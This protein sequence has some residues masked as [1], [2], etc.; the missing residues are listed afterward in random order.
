[1]K[2]FLL[3]SACV[4]AVT[5][6]FGSEVSFGDNEGSVRRTFV[7]ARAAQREVLQRSSSEAANQISINIAQGN[8]TFSLRKV[9]GAISTD[10]SFLLPTTLN[11]VVKQNSEGYELQLEKIESG[12]FIF[13][14][15]KENTSERIMKGTFSINQD[16]ANTKTITIHSLETIEDIALNH[17]G[18]IEIQS[19]SSVLENSPINIYIQSTAIN[20]IISIARRHQRSTIT[21]KTLM[22]CTQGKVLQEGLCRAK[23]LQVSCSEFENSGAMVIDSI[24]EFATSSFKNRGNI[25]VLEG[26]HTIINAETFINYG[27]ISTKKHLKLCGESGINQAQRDGGSNDAEKRALIYAGRCVTLEFNSFKNSGGDDTRLSALDLKTSTESGGI[28]AG[29]I[30]LQVECMSNYGNICSLG[31][32][33]GNISSFINQGD[34]YSD[35]NIDLKL[36]TYDDK[37][38]LN[39]EFGAVLRAK[40]RVMLVLSKQLVLYG[41]I[42]AKELVFAGGRAIIFGV[43]KARSIIFDTT[44]SVAVCGE[45]DGSPAQIYAE[46]EIAWINVKSVNLSK[47][48]LYA[49][50]I[51]FG[52][53]H[54]N[55]KIHSLSIGEDTLIHAEYLYFNLLDLIVSGRDIYVVGSRYI[56]LICERG[57]LY[58]KLLRMNLQTHNDGTLCIQ[59]KES[60]KIPS[61]KDN[62]FFFYH[63]DFTAKEVEIEGEVIPGN[64]TIALTK[65]SRELSLQNTYDRGMQM[66]KI[67]TGKRL[68]VVGRFELRDGLSVLEIE[69]DAYLEILG[70]MNV[71]RIRNWGTLKATG[72]INYVNG[73]INNHGFATFNNLYLWHFSSTYLGRLRPSF[74]IKGN[75]IFCSE[76]T[77]HE[78]FKATYGNN[79]SLITSSISSPHIF[80]MI[81]SDGI[82]EGNF[83]FHGNIPLLSKG[84][85]GHFK[86][87]PADPSIVESPHDQNGSRLSVYKGISSTINHRFSLFSM[88]A[89]QLTIGH[90]ESDHTEVRLS[91]DSSIIRDNSRITPGK[92]CITAKKRDETLMDPTVLPEVPSSEVVVRLKPPFLGSQKV[93]RL[94]P[95]VV[96]FDWKSECGLGLKIQSVI[97]ILEGM[98]PSFHASE[99]SQYIRELIE[100]VSHS[101]PAHVK[102][103]LEG[104]IQNKLLTSRGVPRVLEKAVPAGTKKVCKGH[105]GNDKCTLLT[106]ARDKEQEWRGT[107]ANDP[108]IAKGTLEIS[109]VPE[110]K[111]VDVIDGTFEKAGP[112]GLLAILLAPILA[113]A[114]NLAHSYRPYYYYSHN[115]NESTCN[116]SKIIETS[117]AYTARFDLSSVVTPLR[118]LHQDILLA[119]EKKRL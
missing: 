27:K 38:T 95:K 110:F 4:S 59:T 28:Q 39:L 42:E 3:L 84:S 44:E 107:F 103:R 70:G 97:N 32:I 41:L 24:G 79:S 7:E 15:L 9:N 90:Q 60:L 11:S 64:L 115:D 10:L 40:S 17:D 46:V 19:I 48:R 81:G 65:E 75:L 61:V 12:S 33:I 67:K 106:T 86:M 102:L 45:S 43:A 74:T 13:V 18:N 109:N 117:A 37:Q 68:W 114:T 5:V 21:A 104:F 49:K 62:G 34:V 108:T 93:K 105:Q 92:I 25:S 36:E 53:M 77:M 2:K 99:T 6:N 57:A 30:I 56:G 87:E 47:A 116:H 54:V 26:E 119:I 72:E 52:K 101:D 71:D 73:V 88:R 63:G 91:A 82:V 66:F 16:V 113:P 89:S 14:L 22:L 80:E 112:V 8:A 78:V 94:P 111:Y 100:I 55:P 85:T 83:Y 51:C 76:N 31:D 35:S 20:G 98:D 96:N 23:D 29:R 58:D 50:M 118:S 1:M 69:Q